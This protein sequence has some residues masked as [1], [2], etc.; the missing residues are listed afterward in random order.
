MAL[1]DE[2]EAQVRSGSNPAYANYLGQ[3]LAA[4]AGIDINSNQV[5]AAPAD[6]LHSTAPAA[7]GSFWGGV[8][9]SL[10]KATNTLMGPLLGNVGEPLGGSVGKS[11]IGGAIKSVADALDTTSAAVKF[12]TDIPRVATTVL[13]LILI[14]AGIFALARGPAVQIVSGAVKE[15]VTS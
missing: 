8:K 13:G 1:V 5:S 9:S 12:I 11:S 3:M 15:A 2:Y 14:I 6:L 4:K 7:E 10:D